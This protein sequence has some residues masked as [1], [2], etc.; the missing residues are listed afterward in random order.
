MN[1]NSGSD[2]GYGDYTNVSTTLSAGS[3]YTLSATEGT[4]YNYDQDWR[5]WIDFNGDGIFSSNEMVLDVE[6][7]SSTTVSSS[8]NV[9]STASGEVRMRVSM[10]Y[11]NIPAASQGACDSFTYGEVEDYTINLVEGSGEINYC[12]SAAS[13][14]NYF[15]IS[16]VSVGSLNN[17]S[18]SDNGLSLIHI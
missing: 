3:T 8:F 7:T 6:N 18:G 5:A 9:P 4:T 10:K 15:H 17:N 2:N 14:S 16:N 11:F 13:N 1:N 12:A